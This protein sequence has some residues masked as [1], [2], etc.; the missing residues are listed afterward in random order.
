MQ[1][2]LLPWC[3]SQ[4][5]S[6]NASCEYSSPR[7][8]SIGSIMMWFFSDFNTTNLNATGN[9]HPSSH[10]HI[11]MI[12][13][14]FLCKTVTGSLPDDLM[15]GF[16]FICVSEDL[17]GDNVNSSYCCVFVFFVKNWDISYVVRCMM[18]VMRLYG[19][20]PVTEGEKGLAGMRLALM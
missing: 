20:Q 9:T 14:C 19:S 10:I 18:G 1:T 3:S 7:R 4:R 11:I 6:L 2:C 15:C 13:L 16:C 5:R 8:Y 12:A 17:E